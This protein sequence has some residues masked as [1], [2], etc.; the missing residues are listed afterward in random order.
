MADYRGEDTKW[1][2]SNERFYR[3]RGIQASLQKR[4]HDAL[5]SDHPSLRKQ[6]EAVGRVITSFPQYEDEM[7]KIAQ[8]TTRIC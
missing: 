2:Y 1:E 7:R 4:L 8:R 3:L 5:P 6:I